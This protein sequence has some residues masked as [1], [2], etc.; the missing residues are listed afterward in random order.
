MTPSKRD[1]QRRPPPDDCR[2]PRACVICCPSACDSVSATMMAC[3]IFVVIDDRWCQ[4]PISALH[5]LPVQGPRAARQALD[6]S[7]HTERVPV[8]R[9]DGN[10]GCVVT[11]TLADSG[12]RI[13]R[14]A[15][16]D[17]SQVCTRRTYR[18][19]HATHVIPRGAYGDD[20]VWPSRGT[21]HR[22]ERP[23]PPVSS[24]V[25]LPYHLQLLSRAV[26]A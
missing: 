2:H 1:P 13:S 24:I 26:I 15:P 10:D 21:Q 5:S 12:I 11:A 16:S 4:F 25:T 18:E 8:W 20:W 17:L 9:A 22:S 6:I 23:L 19:R 7:D 14:A 3:H